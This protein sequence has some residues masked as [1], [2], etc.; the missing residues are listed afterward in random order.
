MGDRALGYFQGAIETCTLYDIRLTRALCDCI[1]TAVRDFLLAQQRNALQSAAK[2]LPGAV[3]I[4]L[5][6]RQQLSD[7]PQSLPRY[8]EIMI[9]L[10]KA[11]V[12]SEK[13]AARKVISA[14]PEAAA[15]TASKERR[16]ANRPDVLNVL[17]ASPSDVNEERD[18]VTAAI[19]DWNAVNAHPDTINILLQP[20]RWETHSYPE[21]GD[22]PQALLNRQIV[23]RGDFLIGIFGT[24]LG[25]PTGAAESGTIEEIEQ[26]RTA[27]K[28]VALYFSSAP[29]PRDV[30][31]D[32]LEALE[33][34]K[35]ARKKDTKYEVFSSADD[36]RRQ[37]SQHLTG[38]VM[39]IAKPL[40]LGMWRN[41]PSESTPAPA[42]QK[43]LET[44]IK[45]EMR[46][47][48]AARRKAEQD[49]AEAARWRPS[50]SINSKVEG[51]EQTNK[52]ILKSHLEFALVEASLLS[53]AGAKLHDYTVGGDK[54]FST[55][56]S[57]PI[58]HE[59]LLK[60][61]NTSQSY[62]QFSTFHGSIKYTVI[63]ERDGIQFTGVLPFN[64]E[65]VTVSNTLWFKLS[66]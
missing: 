25:T 65:T 46:Q 52:L 36:L 66:G 32:Q 9:A 40:Q 3:A 21:S 41:E 26:F 44:I 29:V 62:F 63:W 13:A 18:A 49:A 64:A 4:P 45:D 27:G 1:E 6:S 28:Y 56:F 20:I 22:R 24:R 59:S 7:R 35:Q 30:D 8:N 60:I 51:Q 55:G 17:I 43:T 11:R 19:H 14:E 31:R 37:V 61:A 58:T 2:N 34:Y 5:S 54:L 23:A 12:E 15:L 50:A 39:S 53:P 48:E 16:E 38:I 10:E 33:R 42:I 47:A 57:V